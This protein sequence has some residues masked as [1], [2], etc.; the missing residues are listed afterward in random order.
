MVE[1]ET[2]T[3]PSGKNEIVYEAYEKSGLGPE[4]I[5][6]A[7][8]H[9]A[10]APGELRTYSGL[11]FC[12]AGQE[13]E[14]F[15]EGHTQITGDIPVNP[16]GGLSARG[17]PI[18]A[19]GLYMIGELTLQLRGE[20]GARQVKGRKGQGVKVAMASNGGGVVE[21]GSGASCATILTR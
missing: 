2:Q 8:V 9:D 16:S 15:R 14:F 10:V 3:G 18:G 4:D 5:D 12:E 1:D 21:G 6:V 13:A 19:T 17:H 11:G 20:A 7:E